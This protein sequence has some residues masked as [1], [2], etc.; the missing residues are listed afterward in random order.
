MDYTGRK[1]DSREA[2][3]MKEIFLFRHA[4]SNPVGHSGDDHGRKLSREGH[5]AAS[6]VGDQ[7]K[8]DQRLPATVLASDALRTQQTALAAMARL[9]HEELVVTLPSLYDASPEDI[10]AL[11]AGR[12]ESSIMVVG[13][14]PSIEELAEILGGS[15]MHMRPGFCLWLRFDIKQWE[16]LFSHPPAQA[17]KLYKPHEDI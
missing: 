1:N 13:H 8:A 10:L 12:P 17:H 9:G 11:L 2:A 15:L 6:Q 4:V 14:N 5:E 16:E 7:L 3:I